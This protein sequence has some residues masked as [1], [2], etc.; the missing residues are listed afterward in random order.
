M[1]EEINLS[2]SLLVAHPSLLDPNFRKSVILVSL[3][4][5]EE[6]TVG[7]LI[8]RPLQTTLGEFNPEFAFG[9]LKDVPLYAGGPVATDQMI[10]VAWH[11]S[12]ASDALKLYFGISYEKAQSLLMDEPT[13]Q[14]RGFLGYAGWGREQ[15][16]AEQVQ[17]AWMVMPIERQTIESEQTDKLWYD[18]VVKTNPE[19]KLLADAP[20]DP[21][22]N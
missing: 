16:A 12:S 11:W 8:N 20:D 4:S 15:L 7:V 21:S 1:Q 10:L 3:D 19:L 17:N 14:I 6:G 5:G 9:A 22:V 2:G 18:L 13:L